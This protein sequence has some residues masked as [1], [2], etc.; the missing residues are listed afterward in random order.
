VNKAS[1]GSKDEVVTDANR[2]LEVS[3]HFLKPH[4]VQA[5]W[6][7][8]KHF[9]CVLLLNAWSKKCTVYLAVQSVWNMFFCCSVSMKYVFLLLSQ[10]KMCFFRLQTSTIGNQLC[11]NFSQIHQPMTD[12]QHVYILT[13]IAEI[14]R[15]CNLVYKLIYFARSK[16][17]ENLWKYLL[18]IHAGILLT[19]AKLFILRYAV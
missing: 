3:C 1:L 18:F 16:L 12:C 4:C 15:L 7:F 8:V 17:M 10:Y 11:K 6:Y 2:S 14:E 19:R 9:L 5:F 13:V